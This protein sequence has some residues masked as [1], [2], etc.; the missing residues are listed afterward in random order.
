[1]PTVLVT[2]AFG[3]AHLDRL[4]RVSPRLTVT[5]A[6]PETADYSSAEILYGGTSPA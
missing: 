1:M 5:R 2:T 6:D 4:R 3:E